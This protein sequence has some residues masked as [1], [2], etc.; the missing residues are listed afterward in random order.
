MFCSM[1]CLND[2][3]VVV[4][5]LGKVYVAQGFGFRGVRVYRAMRALGSDNNRCT[6][7]EAQFASTMGQ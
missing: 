1:S 6:S 5:W 4:L 2:G 7:L 3:C